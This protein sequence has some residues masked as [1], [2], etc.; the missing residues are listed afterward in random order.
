MAY[1]PDDY[2]SYK[3]DANQKA[4]EKLL[5]KARDF[6]EEKEPQR[7]AQE[8]QVEARSDSDTISLLKRVMEKDR[9]L[10]EVEQR[11]E[12]KERELAVREGAVN[13][14]RA[15]LDAKLAES[16]AQLDEMER[17]REASARLKLELEDWNAKRESVYAQLLN[18]ERELGEREARVKAMEVRAVDNERDLLKGLEILQGLEKRDEELGRKEQELLRWEEGKRIELGMLSKREEQAK[19]REEELAY[20]EKELA[21]ERAEVH[22]AADEAVRARRELDDARR[23]ADGLAAENARLAGGA[24]EAEARRAEL[25]ARVADLRVEVERAREE[26]A[27][28]EGLLAEEKRGTSGLRSEL[29]AARRVISELES[30]TVPKSR[31]EEKD[32]EISRLREEMESAARELELLRRD[33]VGREALDAKERDIAALRADLDSARAESRARAADLEPLA[34]EK[35]ELAEQVARYRKLLDSMQKGLQKASGLDKALHGL[36]KE[37]EMLR[38]HNEELMAKV[39]ALQSAKAEAR[40][41]D[42]EAKEA[43]KRAGA[44]EAELKVLREASRGLGAKS[45]EAKTLRS[46]L[47]KRD[48]ELARA[49]YSLGEAKKVAEELEDRAA[50]AA[51]LRGEAER[52]RDLERR[53]KDL[54]RELAKSNARAYEADGLREKVERLRSELDRIGAEASRASETRAVLASVE[55]ER[56]RLRSELDAARRDS[57]ELRRTRDAIGA[58]EVELA[59]AKSDVA[60]AQRDLE[61]SKGVEGLLREREAELTTLKR[62]AAELRRSAD[63]RDALARKVEAMEADRAKL[64]AQAQRSI[65]SVEEKEMSLVTDLVERDRRI[66][67]LEA[68]LSNEMEAEREEAERYAEVLLAKQAEIERLRGGGDRPLPRR[69]AAAHAPEEIQPGRAVPPEASRPQAQSPKLTEALADAAAALRAGQVRRSIRMLDGLDTQNPGHP[70]VLQLRSVAHMKLGDYHTAFRDL[71]D[72]LDAGDATPTLLLS[73]GY[74][75]MRM[76]DHAEALRRFEEALGRGAPEGEALEG[77]AEA[78]FELGRFEDAAETAGRLASYEGRLLAGKSLHRLG[79][80]IEAESHLRRAV[81]AAPNRPEAATE[82]ARLLLGRGDA[83]EAISWAKRALAGE[84]ASREAKKVYERA[85][86]ELRRSG[87]TKW[88]LA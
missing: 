72:A 87:R 46:E 73:M 22:K 58:V 8:Q 34:K 48:E 26:A 3:M 65:A 7:P 31:L 75:A 68:T 86:A 42:D 45:D 51:L 25:D 35:A 54:E 41:H 28:S 81:D 33:T 79:R 80:D 9:A 82:M 4:L 19:V 14:E 15:K 11:L 12:A 17:Q 57:D 76:R 64:V 13:D 88:S 53:I 66:G 60:Q 59:K 84:P 40:S 52:S 32:G 39:G 5:R 36:Q 24:K 78:M 6:K 23:E 18:M 47:K 50:K 38:R 70:K 74:C 21:R 2:R 49:L 67:E 61:W 1:G 85:L 30:S 63:E 83:E 77:A 27:K 69:T 29:D 56:D 71:R 43:R 44:L 62:E 10:T 37:S 55:S 20:R 16:K